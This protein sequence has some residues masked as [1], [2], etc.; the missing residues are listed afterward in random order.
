MAW[1]VALYVVPVAI[2]IYFGSVFL[3]LHLAGREPLALLRGL[4]AGEAI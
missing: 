1:S 2:L 3:F 4:W